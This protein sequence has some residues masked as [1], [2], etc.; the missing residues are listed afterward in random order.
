MPLDKEFYENYISLFDEKIKQTYHENMIKISQ[1][2]H[3]EYRGSFILTYKY[4]PLDYEIIIENEFRAYSIK[5][6]DSEGASNVL[7]RIKQHKNDL[8]EQNIIE[9]L[10]ILKDVLE[11]NNFNLFFNKDDKIYQ[12]N[13]EGIRRIKDIREILNG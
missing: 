8:N 1:E 3:F 9:S 4:I 7:C 5:I 12:K 10:L 11:Q 13:K 6:V 2:I